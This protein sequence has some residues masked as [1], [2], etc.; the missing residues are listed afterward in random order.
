MAGDRLLV[1]ER[2]A[3]AAIISRWEWRVF[4]SESGAAKR[5]LAALTPGPAEESDELY[6]EDPSAVMTA[7]HRVGLD[8]H[9]N[10][11]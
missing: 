11:S 5:A 7:V 9:T 4:S 8:G 2:A 10:T 6:S 3:M 1:A